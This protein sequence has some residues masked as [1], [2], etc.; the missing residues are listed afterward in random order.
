MRWRGAIGDMPADLEVTNVSK[1][2]PTAAGDLPILTGVNLSLSRGEELVVMGPSGAGKSTLLYII[3]TLDAP[4]GGSVNILGQNPFALDRSTLARF[5][6][7]NIGFVFQD[8]YLLPQ[9]TVLENV[10]IPTLAGN[11]ADK[12]AEDRANCLAKSNMPQGYCAAVYRTRDGAPDCTLPV[13]IAADLDGGLAIAR[14]RCLRE[15]EAA[16]R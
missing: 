11:G 8:H 3:G 16:A 7:A 4:S 15:R 1:S 9:C 13:A 5:R 6:N 10:L 14:N 12:A 2:F